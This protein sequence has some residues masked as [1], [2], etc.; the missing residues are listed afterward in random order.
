MPSSILGCTLCR[1]D[2]RSRRT[3]E[4]CSR[5]L[6]QT[7]IL[8]HVVSMDQ[9]EQNIWKFLD[10]RATPRLTLELESCGFRAAPSVVTF[11]G[12]GPWIRSCQAAGAKSHSSARV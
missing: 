5:R 2:R 7:T 8:Q 9:S 3:N 11:R 12:V 4:E 10:L 1:D 6:L